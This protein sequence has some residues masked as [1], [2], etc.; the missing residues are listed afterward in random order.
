ETYRT[1]GRWGNY[2][3]NVHVAAEGEPVRILGAWLGNGVNECEIWAPKINKI[4]A[5]ITHWKNSSATLNGKRH[6]V[7]M[8][9]GGMSQ[10]LTN[11]QRMP[12]SVTTRLNKL[13][14]EYV[15]NDKSAPPVQFECL[16]LP[17]E[18]GGL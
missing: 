13:I 9:I 4:L 2:P 11:V 1:T 8:M 14:R 5:V 6:V 16:M 12:K 3:T 18:R 15:W 17:P 10:F 7:Q